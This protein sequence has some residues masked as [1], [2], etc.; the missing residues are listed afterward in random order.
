[1]ARGIWLIKNGAQR[2]FQSGNDAPYR[3]MGSGAQRSDAPYR[4]EE[5]IRKIVFELP[6]KKRF[7]EKSG[8]GHGYWV[9]AVLVGVFLRNNKSVSILL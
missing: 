6:A 2:S 7:L 8:K 4:E 9:E 3:G 5:V 1:M